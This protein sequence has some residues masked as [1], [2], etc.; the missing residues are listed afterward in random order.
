MSLLQIKQLI[1]FNLKINNNVTIMISILPQ[2]PTICI[3]NNLIAN[4]INSSSDNI[5]YHVDLTAKITSSPTHFDVSSRPIYTVKILGFPEVSPAWIL[6][7]YKSLVNCELLRS[8]CVVQGI[9]PPH[10]NFQPNRFS[11]LGR[12]RGHV[13]FGF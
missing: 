2:A 13:D 7:S 5:R 8:S 10:N 6:V 3:I 12:E 11:L 4:N 9:S 1:T